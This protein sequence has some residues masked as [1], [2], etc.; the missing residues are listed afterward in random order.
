MIIR[1]PNLDLANRIVMTFVALGQVTGNW[2]PYLLDKNLDREIALRN[3]CLAIVVNGLTDACE[4][5]DTRLNGLK[6]YAR[7]QSH[8]RA[9]YYLSIVELYV[10]S[11]IDLLS[12]L[13]RDEMIF[14]IE[15]R[16][17]YVH[18]HLANMH[19]TTKSVKY[20]SER[21]II[22]TKISD[23]DYWAAYRTVRGGG[24]LEAPMNAIRAKIYDKATLFWEI[25]NILR[26]KNVQ[27][28]IYDDLLNPDPNGPVAQL[29]FHDGGYWET[30]KHNPDRLSNL[31]VSRDFLL[32]EKPGPRDPVSH[33]TPIR[34][35]RRSIKRSLRRGWDV[36]ALWFPNRAPPRWLNRFLR[37]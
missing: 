4:N 28:A 5:Y 10:Q 22:S 11:A 15:T 23:E 9:L 3:K 36:Y 34:A 1:S 24:D 7:K 16:H 19:S 29:V 18:G 25:D 31:H 35:M 6:V 32:Y 33:S 27:K 26:N 37:S 13:S 12:V 30:I 2:V 14:V 17:Q 20:V 8:D 21:K